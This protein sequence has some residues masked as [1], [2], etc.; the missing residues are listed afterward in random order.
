MQVSFSQIGSNPNPLCHCVHAS[1]VTR[2]TQTS[3]LKRTSGASF[4]RV[5]SPAMRIFLSV[6]T[7]TAKRLFG[8]NDN[9]RFCWC[10]SG[11]CGSR[12]TLFAD[13]TK[14]NVGNAC[15]ISAFLRCSCRQPQ[16][17]SAVPV[18]S[19]P[20]RRRT[21]EDWYII[22][23]S[24]PLLLPL[25]LSHTQTHSIRVF[26]PQV[27][28][29]AAIGVQSHFHEKEQD[30]RIG[31]TTLSAASVPV[32]AIDLHGSSTTGKVVKVA[33]PYCAVSDIIIAIKVVDTIIFHTTRQD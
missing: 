25:S 26:C 28:C 6:Q 27:L 33:C 13:W 29:C 30:H 19:S 10:V 7:N 3:Q 18:T 5:E 21:R 20:G 24:L 14:H 8:Q 12:T 15:S 11:Q 32:A 17:A 16:S 9:R 1:N 4:D 2:P 22:V 23:A 31:L